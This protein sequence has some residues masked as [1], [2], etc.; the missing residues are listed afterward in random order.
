MDSRGLACLRVTAICWI[1]FGMRIYAELGA[2]RCKKAGRGE[3]V[4]PSKV[5][6]CWAAA[7]A[8][9]HANPCPPQLLWPLLLQEA[10]VLAHLPPHPHI[11]GYYASWTERGIDGGEQVRPG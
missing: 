2:K 4:Y 8:P 3:A 10:Q 5:P 7:A 11:V 6:A 1:S 9:V